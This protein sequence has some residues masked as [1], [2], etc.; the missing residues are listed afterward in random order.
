MIA[1]TQIRATPFAGAKLATKVSNGSTT[2]MMAFQKSWLPGSECPAYL[3]NEI[4]SYGFDP[5]GLAADPKGL[6]RFRESEVYHGRWAML[7]VAGALG[8]EVLGQGDWYSAPLPLVQGGHATYFGQEVP[9]DLGTL[10]AIELAGMAAAE[11]LRGQAE[12]EKRIYPGGSFDPMGM[13]KGAN[14]DELKLK[15]IKN[16]RLAMLAFIGFIGQ[17]QAN[18]LTPLGA[19]TSHLSNPLANNFANSP[20]LVS[21]SAY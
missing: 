1:A 14:A 6:E 17:H 15:E 12:T 9:F 8:V 2:R 10:T 4:G 7:G 19:L 18:G 21:C 20:A 3:K 13:A 11:T 5:L 16:G